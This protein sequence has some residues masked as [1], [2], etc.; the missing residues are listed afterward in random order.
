MPKLPALIVLGILPAGIV[1]AN[2][3]ALLPGRSAAHTRPA[4]VLRAE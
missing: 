1:I 3:L 4:L 2:A